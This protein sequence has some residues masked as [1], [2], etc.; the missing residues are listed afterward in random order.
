MNSVNLIGRVGRDP[1]LKFTPK[2]TAVCEFSLAVDD[3]W[4]ENK[5][6]VW[7]DVT[8]WGV[9]AE[10]CGAHVT[11]GD[12]LGVT[13]RLS[14]D[15][16]TDKASGQKRTKIKITAEAIHF[17]GAK[18]EGG[19]GQQQ[20]RQQGQGPRTGHQGGAPPPGQTPADDDDDVP[21]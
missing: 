16:W 3:G 19:E 10:T 20:R 5:K 8:L 14:M 18:R 17:C 12:K 4:G 1:E 2:G 7:L 9:T 6:T 13:G 15:E 21:F 11:K